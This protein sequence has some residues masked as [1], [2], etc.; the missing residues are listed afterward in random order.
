MSRINHQVGE[1]APEGPADERALQDR[2]SVVEEKI[3]RNADEIVS[4]IAADFPEFLSREIRAAFVQNPAF[5]DTKSD[6]EIRTIK[7]NLATVSARVQE[8]LVPKLKER[9][10][11]FPEPGRE[12][13]SPSADLK[14]NPQA[15]DRIQGVGT[16]LKEI[17]VKAG[18]P[19]AAE[20]KPPAYKLPT[21]F[22]GGR[23]LVTLVEA[24]WQSIE[25][26]ASLKAGL[27]RLEVHSTKTRLERRWDSV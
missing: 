19:G 20:A 25:E 6:D 23:L 11:W 3:R 27:E 22:I 10:I 21:W 12:L 2:L 24:Y 9:D 16:Y 13:R 17:L 14:D 4:V 15:H 26:Y 8:E 1:P 5:A 7:R 18:F